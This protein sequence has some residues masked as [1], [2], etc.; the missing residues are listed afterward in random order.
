MPEPT[1]K[2]SR[3]R[4]ATL[5]LLASSLILST[6]LTGCALGGNSPR[7]QFLTPKFQ[8]GEL[9]CLDAPR[10]QLPTTTTNGEVSTRIIASDEAG[11]DCRQKLAKAKMKVE[12]FDE[13]V[14]EM[15]AGTAPKKK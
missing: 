5:L 8:S 15:N 9:N 1:S 12:V 2:P 11:E 3:K 7:I 10:G 6:S 13:V 14:K 4:S